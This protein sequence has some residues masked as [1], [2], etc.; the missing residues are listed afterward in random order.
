MSCEIGPM[1]L[2]IESRIG[3]KAPSER[4]WSLIEDLQG[5]N[6]W[7]PIERDVSGVITFGGQLTLTE[8]IEGLPERQFQARIASWQP[9]AQLALTEKRG[10]QFNALRYFEI[11]E[12]DR[13]SCIMANGLILSGFRGE[14]FY[15]KHR[16]NL[17]AAFE[18]ISGSMK[19]T[20]ESL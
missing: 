8:T 19:Q 17:R 2:R 1:T 4:I 18:Q 16:R 7:N 13:G 3:I 6:R 9:L 15:D 12:L 14:S 10:W 5:W 20:A 11:D